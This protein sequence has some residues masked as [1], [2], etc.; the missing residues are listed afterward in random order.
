[1]D[2]DRT[3]VH[4]SYDASRKLSNNVLDLWHDRIAQHVPSQSDRAVC[5]Q[6]EL[7]IAVSPAP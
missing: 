7:F 5:E 6:I 2:Y 3:N 4:L 1:M